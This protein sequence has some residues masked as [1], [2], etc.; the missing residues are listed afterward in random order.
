ML[1]YYKI[2]EIFVGWQ[3]LKFNNFCSLLFLWHITIQKFEVSKIVL[4]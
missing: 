4:K 3:T 2:I 1:F